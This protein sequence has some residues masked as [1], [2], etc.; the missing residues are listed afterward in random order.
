MIRQHLPLHALRGERYFRWRGGDV[1]RIEGITDAVIALAMTL[2]IVSLEVPADFRGLVDTFREL[3][4]FAICF[5][6]LV[7]VWYYHFQ[8]HRRFGLENLPVVLLNAALLFLLLFY[9]YP[10]KFLFTQLIDGLLYDEHGIGFEDGRTLMLLY[11]SGVVGVFGLFATMH[12]YAYRHRETLELTEVE[13][14]VTRSTIRQHLIHL[15]FGLASVLL[16]LAARPALAGLIYFGIGPVQFL[17]GWI[18]GRRIERAAA[19]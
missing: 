12:G 4:A 13:R 19:A 10:L 2:L 3:P 5:A 14:L 17:N 16:A 18:S 8:F 11:S 15:A 9:V 1:S 7:M 6:L